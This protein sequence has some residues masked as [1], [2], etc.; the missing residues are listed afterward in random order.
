MTGYRKIFVDTAVFIYYL[1]QN[2]SYFQRA[3]SFFEECYEN[4][5]ELVTSVVTV[6]EYCVYPYMNRKQ[7]YIDNFQKFISK[8]GIAV[9]DI[10]TDIAMLA[11]K[12]RSQFKGFKGMD[13]M[14]IATAEIAKCDLF[15]TNDKQLCQYE[16]IK[17]ITLEEC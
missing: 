5:V 6:E 3:K 15:L 16:N 10:N 11:A 7:E 13:A 8:L 9:H 14:Q 12:I 2:P 17:C 1:E 4:E